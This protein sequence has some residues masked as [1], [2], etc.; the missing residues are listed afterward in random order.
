MKPIEKIVSRVLDV[1]NSQIGVREQ[2][3]TNTGPEVNE[4]L[5]SVALR[6]GNPWCAAFAYWCLHKV[7]PE[8]TPLIRTG[9][10]AAISAWAKDHNLLADTPS[11]GDLFL[12]YGPNGAHHTGFVKS[13][14]RD[15]FQT[16]EGNTNVGGSGEG[17]T[18]RQRA[19]PVSPSI[20]FVKWWKLGGWLVVDEKEPIQLRN[21][22][23]KTLCPLRRVLET[24]GH[25]V[26][27][28][29]AK[30]IPTI[31]G[32]PVSYTVYID[33]NTAYVEVTV[34]CDAMGWTC[35]SDGS[36]VHVL[37]RCAAAAAKNT[38]SDVGQPTQYS[39]C[40]HK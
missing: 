23:G 34:L 37:S 19:R 40:C 13:V 9:S 31:D 33:G 8:A 11:P 10:C 15:S 20:K 30:H 21:R 22:D 32:K 26:G 16:I 17:T 36:Y 12:I 24:A 1:A 38:K 4:Y 27:W 25:V 3:T 7:F 39:V 2:G 18:V 5:S 35:T 6:P 28:D 29:S 14:G